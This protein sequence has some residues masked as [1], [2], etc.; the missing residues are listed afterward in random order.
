MVRHDTPL[1]G[2][3]HKRADHAELGRVLLYKALARNPDH[4]AR[5]A[6]ERGEHPDVVAVLKTTS[7]AYDSSNLTSPYSQVLARLIA[8]NSPR[9]VFE[10]M[11]PDMQQVPLRTRFLIA[12][13]AMTASEVSEGAAKPIR[14]LTTTN[15]DTEVTKF[16]SAIAISKEAIQESPDIAARMLA[17]AL[18]EAIGRATDVYFLGKLAGE[19]VGESSSEVNPSWSLVL[20]DLEELTRLVQTGERSRL[21]LIMPPRNCKYLAR[22]ATENGI[23]TVTYDGGSIFGIRII[24]SQ[25][26]TAGRITLADA[27]AVMYGDDGMDVRQSDVA[28]VELLDNPTNSAVTTVTATNV[29]SAFQTNTSILLVERAIAVRVGDTN[30]IATLTGTQWGIGFDSPAG[31]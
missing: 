3:R 16:S 1:T 9:S 5:L 20:N 31:I 19:E 15:L 6:E 25:A 21:Y 29:V 2:L 22:L 14:R 18:P 28:A 7:P 17:D 23:S 12:T 10:I 8:N 26:Q 11:K 24:T 30:G 13:S 4:A 27:S